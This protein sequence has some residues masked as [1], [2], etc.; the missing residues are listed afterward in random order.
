MP[1]DAESE[2]L[3]AFAKDYARLYARFT[4]RCPVPECATVDDF[5][6]VFEA[7]R[8]EYLHYCG[9]TT[10][11]RPFFPAITRELLLLSSAY[12]SIP[13]AL[14]PRGTRTFGLL[15]SFL[16]YATQPARQRPEASVTAVEAA[17]TT[18]AATHAETAPPRNGARRSNRIAVLA[19]SR[20]NAGA[21]PPSS[22]ASA[23]PATVATAPSSPPVP[24]SLRLP[25]QPVPVSVSC[26]R[27][28]LARLDVHAKPAVSSSTSQPAPPPATSTSTE[29][30]TSA[31]LAPLSHTEATVLLALRRANGWH[32]EPYVNQGK[33]V[34]ALL[35]AHHACAAP[36]VLQRRGPPQP[37]PLPAATPTATSPEAVGGPDSLLRD[38]AYVR[39]RQEYEAARRRLLLG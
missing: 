33:H 22:D 21:E 31:T 18:P 2:R 8:V 13:E 15:L 10:L 19:D 11:D 7:S 26:M 5:A 34:S 12:L 1:R 28:L 25:M 6:D 35:A 38:P 24:S 14:A 30:T 29:P 20:S 36:L 17:E 16:L 27:L 3:A 37:R 39:S 32:I 23:E 4:A 9:G